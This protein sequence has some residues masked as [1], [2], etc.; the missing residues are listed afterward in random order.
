MFKELG[1]YQ[2]SASRYKETYYQYGLQLLISK[3][4][5][6]AVT[7]FNAL[8][9][10]QESTAK[11]NEAK[12]GYVT[13]HKNNTDTTTYSYLKD[14]KALGYKDTKDIYSSLYAWSVKLVAFNTSENNETTISSS[15][16]RYCS[17]LH[18]TFELL[19]GPPGEKITLTHRVY[20]PN[21]SVNYS[22][23]YWE[24]ERR[25]YTFGAYWDGFTNPSNVATGTMTVK[26]YNKATGELLGEA[27][28]RITS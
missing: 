28:I 6:E 2:D 8:G 21:G 22:D 23:W 17:Y 1:D 13:T 7:V 12:Y 26:V 11:L 25:G 10:Y 15:V 16:S 19:G 14:L 3:S 9:S 18:F 20:W 4:Y 27:S 24:D 5:K